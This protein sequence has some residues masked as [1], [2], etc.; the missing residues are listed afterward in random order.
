MI[1]NL[2]RPVIGLS[3]MDGITD[4]P[5]RQITKLIGNP[6]IIYTEFCH[7]MAIVNALD[8]I[9]DTFHYEELERPIIAQIY[10]KTPW[11]FYSAS[12]V[13]AALGFDGIDINMGCPAK[14]VVHNG[15]GAGLIR[16]PELALSIINSVNKGLEDWVTDG[17]IT[18]LAQRSL[19]AVQKKISAYRQ[20]IN[21][22]NNLNNSLGI[23]NLIG[24]NREKISVSLKTRTGYDKP[25]TQEWISV[26]TDSQVD[27][28]ALHG[29]TLKQ[30]YGGSADINEL[31]IG[32]QS[33]LKPVL[34]NGDIN[35][36]EKAKEIVGFTGAAGALIGR[37]SFGNPWVFLPQ[38]EVSIKEKFDALL[39]H[40]ELF[41]K[42][43]PKPSD[44]VNLRKHLGWY[45]KGFNG[46]SEIRSRFVRTN[47]FT[48]VLQVVTEFNR[49]E[50]NPVV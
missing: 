9:I 24:K 33:S 40:V 20:R 43:Y 26:I 23:K 30:M 31:K 49:R 46:A 36:L 32:V 44:F 37:A 14:N 29:R 6:N 12:K 1:L 47:S 45:T 22:E 27:F 42:L 18:G 48:E 17:K 25:V 15:S 2:S 10:G 5:F 4:S 3:P 8:N 34:V 16:T 28:I 11:D 41:V 38:K 7:V 50:Q 19:V 13:I 21:L 39:K 35:S